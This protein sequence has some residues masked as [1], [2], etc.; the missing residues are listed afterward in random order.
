MIK[1]ARIG[2]KPD[3]WKEYTVR[4]VRCQCARFCVF[5]GMDGTNAGVP[6]HASQGGGGGAQLRAWQ[7]RRGLL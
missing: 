3:N 2:K 7:S 4:A 1:P 5:L 6:G